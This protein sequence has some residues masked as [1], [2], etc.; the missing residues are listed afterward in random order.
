MDPL[1]A[2]QEQIK[3]RICGMKMMFQPHE[4]MLP[5]AAEAVETIPRITVWELASRLWASRFWALA[6]AVIFGLLCLSIMPFIKPVYEASA[7]IYVDPQNLQVLR[8]DL[9]PPVAAGDSGVVVVESQV[10]IMQSTS[11]LKLV[12]ESL[13]LTKDEE[14]GGRGNASSLLS[15]GP[16]SASTVDPVQQAVERLAKNINVVREDRTYMITVYARSQSATRAAEIS[17]AVVKSYLQLRDKQRTDQANTASESLENRLTSLQSALKVREDAIAKFK[18]DNHIVDANGTVLAESRLSQNSTA[19]STAQDTMNKRKVDRDQLKALLAHPERFLSSPIATA[20]PDL[21]RLRA[22]M[23]ASEADVSTLAATLGERHPRVITARSKVAAVERAVSAEMARLAQYASIEYERSKSEY[24]SAVKSLDPLI[25]QVQDIDSARIELRQLQRDADSARALYEEALTRSR[26]TREQGLLNTI[27]A[28][29]VSPASTPIRRKSPPSLSMML[30]VSVGFGI[31]LGWSLGIG[32]GYLRDR[33]YST[34]RDEI[35][36]PEGHVP[37]PLLNLY[38][39]YSS[40]AP[41]VPRASR[42]E[43]GYRS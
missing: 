7:Q 13:D 16:P 41:R 4:R 2:E 21:M 10:R 15:F 35:K 1:E 26:E 5:K 22:E 32:Y 39:R 33:A 23:E 9:A 29:I 20:S 8:N 43:D 38:D 3:Y 30:V 31:S 6:G 24:E 34:E 19:V 11:V 14:F 37:P 27:N 18:V 42:K 36:A 12:V 25:S 40:D 17:N 28:Q